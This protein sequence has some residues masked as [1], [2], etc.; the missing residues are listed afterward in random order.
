[1]SG[2]PPWLDRFTQRAVECLHAVEEAPSI[3]CHVFQDGEIWEVSLFLSP[4]EI[5]GGE[6]DGERL[7]SLFVADVMELVH[8][9]DTVASASW[10]PHPLTPQDDLRSHLALVGE[11]EGHIVWLRI[12]G[13]SPEQFGV[14]RIAD[15]HGRSVVDTW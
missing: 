5:V 2:H 1:M 6:H 10:Q 14:G 11:F 4:T 8:I 15:F 7:T 12:L 13:E 3:G 9:F